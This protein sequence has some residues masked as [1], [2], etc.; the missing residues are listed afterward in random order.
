M[1]KN[2]LSQT[3]QCVTPTGRH[4]ASQTT[5]GRTVVAFGVVKPPGGRRG[6]A[7]ALVTPVVLGKD[8]SAKAIQALHN[9]GL[10]TYRDA[11]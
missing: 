10:C 1:E 4:E 9:C 8:H 3:V 7:E 6:A 11:V 5:E 2:K